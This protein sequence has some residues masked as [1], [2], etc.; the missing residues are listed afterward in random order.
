MALAL[1]TP[2]TCQDTQDTNSL[3]LMMKVGSNL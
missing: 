3:D 1:E 2:E